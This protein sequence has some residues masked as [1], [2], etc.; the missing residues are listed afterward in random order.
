[1]CMQRRKASEDTEEDICN[2]RK[3]AW[4]ET[5]LILDF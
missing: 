3:G 5:K 2:A 4:E 1:M